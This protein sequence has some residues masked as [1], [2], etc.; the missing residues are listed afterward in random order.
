MTSRRVLRYEIPIDDNFHEIPAGKILHLSDYRQK[1]IT[2]ERAR[3]EVWVETT[4]DGSR[5]L[6]PI[7]GLQRVQVFGTGHPLPEDATHLA[8]CLDGALVWH[9][10]NVNHAAPAVRGYL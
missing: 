10:Y 3:I 1:H 2:G 4:F 9:L 8:T 7:V 6:S 5:V